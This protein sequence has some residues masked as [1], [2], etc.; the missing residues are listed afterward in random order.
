MDDI[1]QS[2]PVLLLVVKNLYH[3]VLQRLHDALARFQDKL[4][5]MNK[6]RIAP[7]YNLH[8]CKN[9]HRIIPIWIPCARGY[10]LEYRD[11]G[12]N[13]E[14]LEAVKRNRGG[15]YYP[16]QATSLLFDDIMTNSVRTTVEH[17]DLRWIALLAALV[18]F[19]SEVIVR[20]V[21]GIIDIKARCK[22]V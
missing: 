22:G 13:P 3:P 11:V 12:N 2:Q 9:G 16:E 20:R 18:V 5:P 6:C 19:L 14:F 10:S 4:N 8:W 15:V 21:H 1:L 7:P 17:T